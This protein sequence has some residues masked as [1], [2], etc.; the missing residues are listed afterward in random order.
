MLYELVIKKTKL[1]TAI[2]FG[3]GK[4]SPAKTQ[5]HKQVVIVILSYAP[6]ISSNTTAINATATILAAFAVAIELWLPDQRR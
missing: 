3:T 6:C 4:A 5:P 1:T 2:Y